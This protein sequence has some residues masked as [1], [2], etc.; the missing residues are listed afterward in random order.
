MLRRDAYR[1]YLNAVASIGHLEDGNEKVIREARANLVRAKSEIAVTAPG[2]VV[3]ALEKLERI[4]TRSPG[5]W[6][7]TSDG[8]T[9]FAS[10]IRAMRTDLGGNSE[11]SERSVGV[12]LLGH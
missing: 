5:A 12:I 9:A 3:T 6:T 2:P 10:L 11:I 7:D 4:V 1:L 8:R